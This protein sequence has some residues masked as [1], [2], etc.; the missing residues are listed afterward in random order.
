MYRFFHKLAVSMEIKAILTLMTV[1]G[2]L[3]LKVRFYTQPELG[4]SLF[5]LG[6]FGQS[7]L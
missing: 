4:L 5:Y 2:G 1:S 7:K 6:V 3:N